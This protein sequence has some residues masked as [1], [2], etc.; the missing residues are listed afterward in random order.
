MKSLSES[1]IT[2]VSAGANAFVEAF[3][4][5]SLPWEAFI[6]SASFSALAH[7]REDLLLLDH[8]FCIAKSSL[9]FS[10]ATYALT[11]SKNL[12]YAMSTE[13]EE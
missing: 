3:D 2:C 5:S 6:V 12:F 4:N 1:Q 7:Y 10:T 9:V 13:T 8:M 11:Y